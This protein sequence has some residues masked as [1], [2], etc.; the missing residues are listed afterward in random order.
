MYVYITFKIW[1]VSFREITGHFVL[2][3]NQKITIYNKELV[4]DLKYVV[5]KKT[6]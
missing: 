2:W 6:D 1:N 5:E 3:I 4:N